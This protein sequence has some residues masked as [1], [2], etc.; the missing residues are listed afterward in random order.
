[1]S[2]I[3]GTKPIVQSLAGKLR[4]SER[5]F[6]GTHCIMWT[7]RTSDQGYGSIGR[8]GKWIS[9]HRWAY[10]YWVNPNFD[11]SLVVDHLCH[12]ADETCGGGTKCEHRRCVNPT[13]LEAVSDADNLRRGKGPGAANSRKTHCPKGH[14]YT[15]ENTSYRSYS[16]QPV[17]RLC[18]TCI[19]EKA[20]Q[21]SPGEYVE[22]GCGGRFREISRRMHVKSRRHLKWAEL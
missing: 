22:C 18:K 9:I 2:T 14:E 15:E 4:L 16:Y 21:R 13:H 19:R 3:K 20:R 10:A 12:N 11:T 6:R 1:M 5:T 8:N 17:Q 7:G